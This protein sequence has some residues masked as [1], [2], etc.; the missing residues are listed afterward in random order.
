M[1]GVLGLPGNFQEKGDSAWVIYKDV[2]CKNAVQSRRKKKERFVF[3]FWKKSSVYWR[4]RRLQVIL[5]F[6]KKIEKFPGPFRNFPDFSKIFRNFQ[7]ISETSPTVG[8][9][10]FSGDF[11]IFPEFS[12]IFHCRCLPPMSQW[13]PGANGGGYGKKKLTSQIKSQNFLSFN[14]FSHLPWL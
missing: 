13:Q 4:S 6:P 9:K 8:Q 11:R 2:S 14:T 12:G 7:K 1:W 5:E 3:F 10:T